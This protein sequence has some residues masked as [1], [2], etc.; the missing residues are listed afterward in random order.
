MMASSFGFWRKKCMINSHQMKTAECSVLSR[1]RGR[2][3]PRTTPA[4]AWNAW[5]TFFDNG[6]PLRGGRREYQ[7][8]A[9]A[10]LASGM[11]DAGYTLVSTLCTGWVK[12]KKYYNPTGRCK[13]T[14]IY[15]LRSTY[16]V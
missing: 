1:G 3:P 16:T 15:I 4:M 8:V 12:N 5:N 6:V 2:V 14:K 13:Y 10:M 9:E 11:V 7:Q